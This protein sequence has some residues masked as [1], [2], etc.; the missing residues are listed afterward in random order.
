VPVGLRGEDD[1]GPHWLSVEQDG[2]AA[3]NPVLAAEVGPGQAQVIAEQVG[4]AGPASRLAHAE[5]AIDDDLDPV[6]GSH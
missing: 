4:E 5:P 3:A 2:A 6:P 1:A